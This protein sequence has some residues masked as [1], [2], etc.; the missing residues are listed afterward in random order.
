MNKLLCLAILSAFLSGAICCAAQE[1]ERDF[2]SAGQP[3][4]GQMRSRITSIYVPERA[5]AP[6]VLTLKT[7][8]ERRFNDDKPSVTWN[9]RE[10]AR[11]RVGRVFEERRS[12]V[13][14][15]CE[16]KPEVRQTEIRDSEARK[17]YFCFVSS[18]SC[19]VFGHFAPE[20]P[21]ETTG[22]AGSSPES[23]S[24]NA[25][26]TTEK[27][28]KQQ[29]GHKTIMGIEVEGF[30]EKTRLPDGGTD[31]YEYWYS[32]LLGLNMLT[33]RSSP[34]VGTVTFTVSKIDLV[35]PDPAL[36]SIPEGFNLVDH[37]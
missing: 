2:P 36:F 5:G 17:E 25:R 4:A 12:F 14:A 27:T 32:S 3:Q 15:G 20:M 22:W 30:L 34:R 19:S 35:E 6:F 21:R 13:P 28:T 23:G 9:E 37:N 24:R 11:D 16:E 33:K 31:S 26:D 10:I 1:Q 7:E 29:L 8:W 18:R